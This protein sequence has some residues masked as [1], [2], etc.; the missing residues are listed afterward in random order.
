MTTLRQ[1]KKQKKQKKEDEN[2]K[3]M[4]CELEKKWKNNNIKYNCIHCLKNAYF[5]VVNNT[6]GYVSDE[7]LI[8]SSNNNLKHK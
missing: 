5:S 2:I 7:D 4:L 3:F 8:L 1:L 6:N